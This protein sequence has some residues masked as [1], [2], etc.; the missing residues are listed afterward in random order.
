VPDTAALVL[1]LRSDRPKELERLLHAML[2]WR[3]KRI[4]GEWFAVTRE[5][6]IAVYEAILATGGTATGTTARTAGAL[7]GPHQLDG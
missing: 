7:I 4:R 6:V 3:G 2:D 5:E 1:E